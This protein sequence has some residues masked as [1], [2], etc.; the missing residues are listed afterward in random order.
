MK[1]LEWVN[2]RGNCLLLNKTLSYNTQTNDQIEIISHETWDWTEI[3]TSSHLSYITP[4]SSSIRN[5]TLIFKV[6]RE[7]T[8]KFSINTK[9]FCTWLQNGRITPYTYSTCKVETNPKINFLHENIVRYM[10]YGAIANKCM[11][12][13]LP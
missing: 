4:S 13:F 5:T 2:L 11:A 10:W 8:W 9:L 12:Y 6:I 1:V 7:V 3:D